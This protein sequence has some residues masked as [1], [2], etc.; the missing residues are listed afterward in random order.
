MT[1]AQA[2]DLV[3]EPLSGVAQ[4]GLL[5]ALLA[6]A[7]IALGL[8]YG[9]VIPRIE[10]RCRAEL[11][12]ERAIA[13]A[14]QREHADEL[15]RVNE[16]RVGEMAKTARLFEDIAA[17]ARALDRFAGATAPAPRRRSQSGSDGGGE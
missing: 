17:V 3:R 13:L 9:V 8:T 5:G 1:A 16:A 7:I 14:A 11:A 4:S 12:A 15:E 2:V 6:L 10:A